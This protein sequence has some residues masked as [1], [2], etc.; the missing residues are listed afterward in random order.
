MGAGIEKGWRGGRHDTLCLV[1]Q[2]PKGQVYPSELA[3]A[4]GGLRTTAK[5]FDSLEAELR[6][7]AGLPE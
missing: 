7:Y 2:V 6:S 5:H 4:R 3:E 1:E